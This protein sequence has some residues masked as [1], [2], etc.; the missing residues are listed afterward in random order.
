MRAPALAL[1]T[2]AE[3]ITTRQLIEIERPGTAVMVTK[4]QGRRY[5]VISR[6]LHGH[7]GWS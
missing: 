4:K 6:V 5:V 1:R 7:Q 2:E 3:G